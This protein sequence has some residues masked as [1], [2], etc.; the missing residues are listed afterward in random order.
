MRVASRTSCFAF[1]DKS[2]DLTTIADKLHV[3]HIIEGSV[4]KSGTSIRITAQL[5]EV[6]T[7][8][9]LWSETYNRQLDDIFSIQDEITRRIF[10]ALKLKSGANE[11]RVKFNCLLQ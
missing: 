7:D 1:K 3:A 10:D 8:S 6:A 5:I 4:R 9:H 11:S 2:V